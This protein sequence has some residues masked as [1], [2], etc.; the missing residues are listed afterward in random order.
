MDAAIGSSSAAAYDAATATFLSSLV[1][2]AYAQFDHPEWNGQIPSSQV[3]QG[4]TQIAAFKVPN[5]DLTAAADAFLDAH[6]ELMPLVSS[7][8][9]ALAADTAAALNTQ[10]S[11]ALEDPATLAAVTAAATPPQAAAAGATDVWFGFALAPISGNLSGSNIVAFRGTRT[12][13]E[14]GL[15]ATAVQVPVPLAWYKDG[16]LRLARVHLGFLILFAFLKPQLDA[17]VKQFNAKAVGTQVTGHS[18]GGAE[19]ALTSIYLKLS[20]LLTPLQSYSQASPRV[21][22]STFV[23]VY[24]YFVR[25]TFRIVNLA[26][27]VP[28]LPPTSLTIVV[29]G[30]K[31]SVQYAHVGQE[32]S[33]LWQTGDVGNNHGWQINYNPATGDDIPTNTPRKYPNSGIPC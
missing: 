5:L 28:I 31:V 33:Y 24:N 8:V 4:Y 11:N 27:L 25:S 32:F 19:T 14:W 12:V 26:D 1:G 15:D 23:S 30:V 18:L 6:P 20:S 13:V 3:P 29:K 7:D 16:K 9:T 2:L 17:A 22:D 21:G 10:L